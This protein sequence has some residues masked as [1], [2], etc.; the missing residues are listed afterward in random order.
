MNYIPVSVENQVTVD[1][2]TQE[3]SVAG[4]S[5]KDKEPTQEYIVHHH[6]PRIFVED[7]VQAAQEKPSKNASKEND[8]HDS[9]DVAFEVEKRNIAS[10]K[11][12]AQVTSINKVNTGRP[13][14]S[15]SNTPL[16]STT[17]TPYA[18]AASTPTDANAGGSS[19]VYLGG[20]I[21]IDASTLP[22]A[23][24]PTDPNMPNLED[25]S[26][27]F[28]NIGIFSEAYDDKDVGVVANFNNMDNTI[29]FSFIP[30]LRIYKDHPKGQ[31]LGDPK[32]AVQTRG[33]IQKA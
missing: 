28:L 22:N 5:G 18:S 20:Q 27:E 33:K 8:V 23:D 3:S 12:A 25:A 29:D 4:S 15:A 9:E 7:V 32:S 19:F 21:R 14:F 1:A 13:F 17:N 2:G 11:R 6:R 10:Q 26:E 31:I 16:V 30:T 24:L